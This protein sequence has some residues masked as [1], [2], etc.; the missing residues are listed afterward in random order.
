[1]CDW[2]EKRTEPMFI[3]SSLSLSLSLFVKERKKGKRGRMI[4]PIE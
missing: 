2:G 1:M 4:I 3:S